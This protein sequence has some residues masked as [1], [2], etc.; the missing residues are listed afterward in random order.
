M[1]DLNGTDYYIYIYNQTENNKIDV[2]GYLLKVQA[3]R[4]NQALRDGKKT[5]KSITKYKPI[6][7]LSISAL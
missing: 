2:I 3:T 6:N 7:K 5:T 1:F 4:F